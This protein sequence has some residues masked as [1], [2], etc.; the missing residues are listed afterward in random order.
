[1]SWL[2][3][4]IAISPRSSWAFLVLPSA[5]CCILRRRRWGEPHTYNANNLYPSETKSD[6]L[7]E[8][9]VSGA[10]LRGVNVYVFSACISPCVSPQTHRNG[11]RFTSSRFSP[12]FLMRL[13]LTLRPRIILSRCINV[14]Y[15]LHRDR[16]FSYEPLMS[17]VLRSASLNFAI[18]KMTTSC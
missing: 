14:T 6:Q 5:R 9:L 17:R 1:M 8:T 3:G 2:G 15:F 10:V 13:R 12:R 11:P 16:H 4:P 7:R 18:V